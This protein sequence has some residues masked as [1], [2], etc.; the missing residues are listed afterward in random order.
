MTVRHLSQ[1]INIMYSPEIS[2]GSYQQ[3]L[4]YRFRRLLYVERGAAQYLSIGRRQSC[5]TEVFGG[6]GQPAQRLAPLRY[7]AVLTCAHKP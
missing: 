2:G 1:F 4:Q 3:G 6:K 7:V 5:D